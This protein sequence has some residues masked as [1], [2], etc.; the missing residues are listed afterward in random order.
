MLRCECKGEKFGPKKVITSLVVGSHC[1]YPRTI[2]IWIFHQLFKLFQE[3]I[4]MHIEFVYWISTYFNPALARTTTT[5]AEASL[6]IHFRVDLSILGSM[7]CWLGCRLL[8]CE[9][10]STAVLMLGP[11]GEWSS[12]VLPPERHMSNEVQVFELCSEI[13][14][15]GIP[16]QHSDRAWEKD[17]CCAW[18]V[19]MLI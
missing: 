11:S 18:N 10:F 9:V 1:L 13:P 4:M 16:A 8:S 15:A 5:I 14:L 12:D 17:K 6:K 2:K 7:L 19:G 3:R